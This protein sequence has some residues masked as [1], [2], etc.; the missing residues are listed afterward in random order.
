[1]SAPL[2]PLQWIRPPPVLVAIL[3]WP[4]LLF[5]EYLVILGFFC[6]LVRCSVVF[7]CVDLH[8]CLWHSCLLAVDT[9]F[10]FLLVYR[11]FI[12]TLYHLVFCFLILWLHLRHTEVPGQG[13]NPS[14]SC[15]NA[16]S[17]T[18]CTTT[19]TPSFVLNVIHGFLSCFLVFWFFF[20]LFFCFFGFLWF[21]F[22]VVLLGR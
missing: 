3:C 13:S 22:V 9:F 19:R 17:L 21:F 15:E 2:G 12:K 16:G 4:T 14:H 1:M 8:S 5:I 20:F 6:S 11:D 18:H 10:P 7:L